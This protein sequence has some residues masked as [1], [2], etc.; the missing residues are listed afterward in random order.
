MRECIKKLVQNEGVVGYHSLLL[1]ITYI[2]AALSMHVSIPWS[3]ITAE[4]FAAL[5]I[6]SDEKIVA[7]Q[8]QERR[9]AAMNEARAAAPESSF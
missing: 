4:E 9:N 5:R 8:D 6:L 7:Q 3:D 1:R 2:D